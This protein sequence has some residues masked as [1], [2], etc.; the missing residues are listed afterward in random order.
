MEH[1]KQK[2]MDTLRIIKKAQEKAGRMVTGMTSEIDLDLL[3]FVMEEM[4]RYCAEK[5]YRVLDWREQMLRLIGYR[6]YVIYLPYL[7]IF[8]IEKV[9]SQH[10]FI[11]DKEMYIDD[12]SSN[13]E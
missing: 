9:H 5:G 13:E 6:K 3:P 10:C 11:Y 8:L 7:D 4:W 12:Q 2:T 1:Q